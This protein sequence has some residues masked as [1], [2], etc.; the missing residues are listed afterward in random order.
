MG[1]EKKI[2]VRA[3]TTLNTFAVTP[4]APSFLFELGS[5]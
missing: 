5:H 2:P 1:A 3:V 4:H